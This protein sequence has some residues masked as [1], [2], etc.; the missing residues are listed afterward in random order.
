MMWIPLRSAKMY[1]F[2]RGSQ[3]LTWCPKWTPDSSRFFIVTTAKSSSRDRASRPAS[4]SVSR[5]ASQP[6]TES[7]Q[8]GPTE[9]I[10]PLG[11]AVTRIMEDDIKLPH[12]QAHDPRPRALK[13]VDEEGGATLNP[14]R[15]GYADP[16]S[17]RDVCIDLPGLMGAK[18]IAES[19]R[20]VRIAPLS[21]SREALFLCDEMRPAGEKADHPPGVGGIRGF[22]QGAIRRNASIRGC[23][24]DESIGGEYQAGRDWKG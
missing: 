4:V 11:D 3:R 2:I 14:I 13:T 15:P 18:L 5:P 21:R 22:S 19:E 16:F 6:A 23:H 20:E 7:S 1:F 10:S 8:N 12:W 9:E 24:A 17:R